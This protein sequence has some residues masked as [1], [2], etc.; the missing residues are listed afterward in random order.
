MNAIYS[1]EELSNFDEINNYL[2]NRA[3]VS[4]GNGAYGSATAPKLEMQAKV[5][6]YLGSETK[7]PLAM[8][9]N[10]PGVPFKHWASKQFMRPN[11]NYSVL[12]EALIDPMF[13]R[14]LLERQPIAR[15]RGNYLPTL[16][17]VINGNE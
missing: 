9:K 16:F 14:S 8:I 11:P 12:E 1:P 4:R 5:Q 15:Q 6:K 17:N 3:E 13:A 7:Q 10:I 2:K